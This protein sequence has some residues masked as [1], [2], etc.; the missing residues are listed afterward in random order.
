MPIQDSDLLL[1]EDTRG[2]S[3]KITASKFKS[4][5]AANA[6]NNYK[7][8]VNKPDYSSRFVYAQNMQ[9]SVAPT[10]YM[11][12]ERA[13]V[14]YK[15]NGQQIIDYFPSVPAGAAGAITAVTNSGPVPYNNTVTNPNDFG[16]TTNSVLL[17]GISNPGYNVNNIGSYNYPGETVIPFTPPLPSAA[18]LVTFAGNSGVPVT[19]NHSN[20]DTQVIPTSVYNQQYPNTTVFVPINS[21]S[22]ITSITMPGNGA[23]SSWIAGFQ[24]SNGEYL[25]QP[26][27]NNSEL[28][29]AN[30]TNL[31]L[32]TA[33]DAIAM[34]DTDGNVTSYTPT[35]NTIS[36]VTPVS[37]TETWSDYFTSGEALGGYPGTNMFNS[38]I[39]EAGSTIANQ[40]GLGVYYT[41]EYPDGV[42]CDFSKLQIYG[43]SRPSTDYAAGL[44]INGLSVTNL[45]GFAAWPD[46]TPI[47]PTFNGDPGSLLTKIEIESWQAGPAIA[48][49]FID[50][51]QL[52]DN[53]PFVGATGLAFTGTA[54]SDNKDL[55]FFKAGDE[56]QPG[57]PVISTD[58]ASN[59]M[60][61]GTGGAWFDGDA[62]GGISPNTTVLDG[63]AATGPVPMDG[64]GG[65]TKM[66]DGVLE[67]TNDHSTEV[68]FSGTNYDSFLTFN[69]PITSVSKV[70]FWGYLTA[71]S[72]G[73]SPST[74][75]LIDG[76]GTE[77]DAGLPIY[78]NK[79]NIGVLGAEIT[80]VNGIVSIKTT[81]VGNSGQIGGVYFDDV[82]TVWYGETTV[83]GPVKSGTGNFYG[84]S[85]PVVG[86]SNSNQD[87]IST[88]NRLGEEFFIKAASTRTGVAILRTKAIAQAQNWSTEIDYDVQ[89]LVIYRGHYW[90][91]KSEEPTGRPSRTSNH[92][93][94]LGSVST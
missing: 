29:L 54:A 40:L 55:K 60:V 59:S 13:G 68:T 56:V 87:W 70:Q 74:L 81:S 12:G 47:T 46:S 20:G 21:S 92:W 19:I 16:A 15:V 31:E 71:S 36:T 89:S 32:F 85:G 6:F 7:L 80:P 53:V 1:I 11:M 2:D 63:S 50:G 22:P 72:N 75:H 83:T 3:F 26:T 65:F 61:V 43:S 17:D 78:R 24:N 66:F 62:P 8:L 52:L 90:V 64:P 42:P 30:T 94:D 48:A 79:E 23:N 37:Y 44:K 18:T 33:G 58:T 10:D 86:V 93:V 51:V 39:G 41:W 45:N 38:T 77:H 57:V 76:N 9:Q 34:V 69:P 82:L 67:T 88:D 5:L 49:V 14:S 35:T 25:L 27:T 91:S 28:T 73:G 84:N 4:N